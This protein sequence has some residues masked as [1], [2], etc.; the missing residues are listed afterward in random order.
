MG[1]LPFWKLLSLLSLAYASTALYGFVSE[2]CMQRRSQRQSPFLFFFLA[3]CPL[4]IPVLEVTR[5]GD[6]IAALF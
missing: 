6:T 1:V 2:T 4:S 5:K 3:F